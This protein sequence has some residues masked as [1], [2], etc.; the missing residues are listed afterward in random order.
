MKAGEEQPIVSL[1]STFPN[2]CPR[3]FSAAK[4]NKRR[5]VALCSEPHQKA[6]LKPSSAACAEPGLGSRPYGYLLYNDHFYKPSHLPVWSSCMF[7]ALCWAKFEFKSGRRKS[8]FPSLLVGRKS[9][10]QVLG[11]CTSCSR[12]MRLSLHSFFGTRCLWLTQFKKNWVKCVSALCMAAIW[13]L[14]PTAGGCVRNEL[15]F[16]GWLPL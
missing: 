2:V 5:R 13:L 3:L 11:Y 15:P 4:T 16:W 9:S 1:T 10:C 8:N 6:Q 14:P 12:E 7:L